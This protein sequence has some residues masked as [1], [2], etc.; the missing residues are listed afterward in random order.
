MVV[1]KTFERG[2][3][4][5]SEHWPLDKHLREVFKREILQQYEKEGKWNLRKSHSVITRK[6]IK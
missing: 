6:P 2:Y 1:I 3:I 4:D 5:F